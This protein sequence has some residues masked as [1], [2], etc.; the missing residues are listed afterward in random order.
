MLRLAALGLSHEANTFATQLMDL[1]SIEAAGVLRGQQILSQHAGGTSTM[2]GFLAAAAQP[3]VEVVPLVMTT[4]VP[5]GKLTKQA[6]HALSQ[7]LV[8]AL[9]ANGPFDG[10]LAALHG[11]AVAEDVWDVDGLLLQRFRDVVGPHVPIGVSLDLHANISAHMCANADVLNTYR[12]NPHIDAKQVAAEV[13]D[14]VIQ[15]AR[16]QIR[17]TIGFEPI[18]AA[19]NILCQ[20]TDTP[21]MRDIIGDASQVRSQPGVLSVSVAEGYPYADVP[22]MGMSVIVVTDANPDAAAEHARALAHRVWRRRESFNDSAIS[23]DEAIRHAI[24]A[25]L[26]PV[27]L[28]DVGDNIG[29]GSPGNSLVLLHAARRL[30]LAS[31]LTIVA[32]GSTAAA[33]HQAG[34]G[35]QL[36]ASLGG[37][38]PGSGP[39]VQAKA[40]VLALHD[41]VYEATGAVHAGMR[42]FNA[43]PSA[44]IALD[45]GQTVIVTSHAVPPLSV[46]QL[47][48]LDLHPSQF[49]AIVAKGVHSPLAG[50]GPHVTEIIQVDTPGITSADLTRFDYQHRR[51]PMYPF[52][53]NTTYNAEGAS[54][55]GGPDCADPR[56][57]PP[58]RV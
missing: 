56:W 20:N 43:G 24:A 11:A 41:G 46:E 40:T 8:G 23:A 16:G 7:E 27:L 45:T 44:A 26:G 32:D 14:L 5:A 9:A 42:Y 58:P 50:Y 55:L 34:I 54:Y 31:L 19:I 6:F 13:A 15:A 47:T 33:C 30:G 35:T 12:T 36:Q 38:T 39:P 1:P 22:E 3:D 28:L 53:P 17:P 48:T 10:V 57:H 29:G 25:P 4:L 2:S 51:R 37:Q 52:E 21:P 49:Q 18:P